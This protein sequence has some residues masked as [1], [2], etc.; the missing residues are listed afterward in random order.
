[1]SVKDTHNISI[2]DGRILDKL[3]QLAKVAS[4]GSCSGGKKTLLKRARSKYLT[5]GITNQLVKISDSFL[6]KSYINTFYC[7][8]TL[9]QKGKKVTAHYC[10]NR[11]CQTCN[12]I[13]TAKL[14]NGYKIPLEQL[15]D[16]QFVTLSDVTIKAEHLEE[17]IT[18]YHKVFRSIQKT[19]EKRKTPI[20]G[21]RKF[22]CT[23][24]PITNEYHPHFHIILSGENVAIDLV[25]EWLKRNPTA[26]RIA[27]DIRV[28]DSDSI[29]E[30]FKYFTK[31]VSKG[32]IYTTAL[33]TIFKAMYGRRVF[34]P[35]GIR[36]D[37]TEDVDE[38]ISEIYQDLE[39][40]ETT[41]TWIDHDWID[42]DTGEMLTEYEP[43]DQIR[44]LLTP[45]DK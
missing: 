33:D 13:R 11:W 22:E 20:V 1:M 8:S 17:E 2:S 14:I 19:F 29:L 43:S 39:S 3:A 28:A 35:M 24:N 6:R 41:W 30:L 9:E 10:N 15:P 37:V 40:R 34:Q 27:Q 36:K 16:K 23:Y 12:R 25:A 4:D 26:N 32:S 38:L 45:V 21:I 7:C 42:R 18:R 31:V 5:N 44:K